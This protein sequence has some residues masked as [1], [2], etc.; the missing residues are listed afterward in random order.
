MTTAPQPTPAPI[1]SG[2]D[3]TLIALK[4]EEAAR[5]LS[6]GRTTMFALIRDGAIQT[7][8]IGHLRRVPVQALNDYLTA[9]MQPH[10]QHLAA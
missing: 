1:D 7:V 5:R 4:V 3:P 8:R 9:R 10:G 2:P 6:I